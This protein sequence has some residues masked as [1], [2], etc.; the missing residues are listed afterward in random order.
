MLQDKSSGQFRKGKAMQRLNNLLLIVRE[1]NIGTLL[2]SSDTFQ[3]RVNFQ[4]GE[5]PFGGCAGGFS[6]CFLL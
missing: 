1:Q 2:Q 5:R 6:V 4:L 3:K